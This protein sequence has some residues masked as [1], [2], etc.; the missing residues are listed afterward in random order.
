MAVPVLTAVTGAVWETDLVSELG[1]ADHGVTVVRRC[2]DLAELLAA[3]A[4]GTARAALLSSDLRRLDRDAVT[5]LAAAGVAVV[6]L[7]DPGDAEAERRLRQLGVAHLLAANAG[8][9]AISVAVVRAVAEIGTEAARRAIGDPRGA[10]PDLVPPP[11]APPTPPGRGRLVAVWGPTGA[12][13][14]TTLAVTVADEASR[15]G[16]PTMLVDADAYGGVV[17]QALG[18]LDESPGLAAACR[19]A[20]AGR[21]DPPMLARLSLAIRPTLRV[22]TGIVRPERWPELRPSALDVVL[23]TARHLASLVVVDLGFCLERDEE[24]AYDT[25]APRR[26]GAALATLYAADAVLCVGGA[27]PVALQ[28]LVRAVGD[29]RDVLPDCRPLVVVNRVRRGVVPGDPEREIAAALV[30]YVGVTDAVYLP[31]DAAATD[32]AIGLGRSLGDVAPDS[33]LRLALVA[34]ARRL[35]GLPSPTGSRR[36]RRRSVV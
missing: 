3:A 10:L 35:A 29:L 31:D 20:A 13:G 17:A 33:P 18:L 14:R 4:T 6:G 27:D 36:R 5:R 8:A 21:L 11:P 12:P 23:D 24:I 1:R 22:L 16:V 34:L 28:R 7:Y 9:A 30:R 19:H 2:V 25:A 15:L 26:N 32:A